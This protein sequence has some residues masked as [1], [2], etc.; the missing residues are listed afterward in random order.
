MSEP[1]RLFLGN[2]ALKLVEEE[3]AA[4]IAAM[5]SEIA[6]RASPLDRLPLTGLELS[7][8]ALAC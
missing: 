4:K 8:K 3:I 1:M 6:G 2:Y 5:K 7:E